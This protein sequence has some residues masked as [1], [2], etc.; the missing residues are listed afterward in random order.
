M[1]ENSQ[2][3]MDLIE[4]FLRESTEFS[5]ESDFGGKYLCHICAD[6]F[7]DHITFEEH[8]QTHRRTVDGDDIKCFKCLFCTRNCTST[9]D[10]NDHLSWHLR[11]ILQ[12]FDF[13][14]GFACLQDAE[15]QNNLP[16]RENSGSLEILMQKP[17]GSLQESTQCEIC[18]KILLKSSLGS[19]LRNRH[20]PE[21]PYSCKDCG[22]SYKSKGSLKIHKKKH[23]K[24]IKS[25]ICDKCGA[26]FFDRKALQDHCRRLH[27]ED[28]DTPKIC[29]ACD[30]S[31]R[32][33]NDLKY[34]QEIVH[35]TLEK[36]FKCNICCLPFKGIQGL[37]RHEARHQDQEILGF[38]CSYCDV[39]FTIET[40]CKLH[41]EQ[42]S[43]QTKYQCKFC[44]E[45]FCTYIRLR[46]HRRRH[47]Q[48]KI[49]KRK[50]RK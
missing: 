20:S 26:L 22:K 46:G 43:G 47:H 25:V 21:K 4:E 30:K 45:K 37:R 7:R 11:D 24:R 33:G 3:L 44:P 8:L 15:V 50:P 2:D 10:M 31:F 29:P 36:K 42:C 1:D 27:R 13:D 35:E 17:S 12:D 40:R 9:C 34:H 41:E 6:K 14:E 19:H 23:S 5:G 39:K 16:E 49:L 28:S 48:E 32:T 18:G 38:H